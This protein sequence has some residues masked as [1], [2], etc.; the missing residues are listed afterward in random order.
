[1]AWELL[2]RI[3]VWIDAA[4]GMA[5]GTTAM[6]SSKNDPASPMS[7]PPADSIWCAGVKSG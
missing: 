6:P 7:D 1:M 2:R 3:N 4:T 5:M